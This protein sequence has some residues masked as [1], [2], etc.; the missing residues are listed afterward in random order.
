MRNL[1][2]WS[3]V[4]FSFPFSAFADKPTCVRNYTGPSGQYACDTNPN[5]YTW[6]YPHDPAVKKVCTR[7]YSPVLCDNSPKEYN[8]VGAKDGTT[9]CV[10][11][12]NQPP[13]SN[14]CDTMPRFY[15]Y[16]LDEAP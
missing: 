6:V 1:T 13:V 15:S 10:L 14:L 7:I 16:I 11:N 5:S 8:E 4:L 2:L 12:Q 9:I 3:L